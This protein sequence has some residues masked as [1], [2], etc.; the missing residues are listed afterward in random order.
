M[1]R[2]ESAADQPGHGVS[3]VVPVDP[4]ALLARVPESPWVALI[5]RIFR[6]IDRELR[7]LEQKA[8]SQLSELS[9]APAARANRLEAERLAL[10]GGV[11]Y[12]THRAR[13]LAL[14]KRKLLDFQEGEP[15]LTE[16]L[17]EAFARSLED[18][19]RESEHLR[20]AVQGLSKSINRLALDESRA[21]MR[22][23]SALGQ[24]PRRELVP[25]SE[26]RRRVAA[27]LRTINEELKDIAAAGRGGLEGRK[28]ELS[29]E[30]LRLI[31]HMDAW[32]QDTS[33]ELAR[34]EFH[35]GMEIMVANP[36]QTE[37]PES[38]LSQSLPSRPTVAQAGEPGG[39]ITVPEFVE[40]AGHG[41]AQTPRRQAPS[42]SHVG[43]PSE[44]SVEGAAA[45]LGESLAP[46]KG[47]TGTAGGSTRRPVKDTASLSPLPGEPRVRVSDE[48]AR[49]DM[50]REVPKLVPF[51]KLIFDKA[52]AKYPS[53]VV[54]GARAFLAECEA[55]WRA[56]LHQ[57]LAMDQPPYGEN[58]DIDQENAL[59][60]D[61]YNLLEEHLASA[62]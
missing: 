50:P 47:E 57:S 40:Q 18:C 11:A 1:T 14:T 49:P 51:N 7:W 2:K 53:L 52:A 16:A 17:Y 23:W 6:D 13:R 12:L 56:P 21:A 25:L 19:V 5:E 37:A 20:R 26:A 24:S 44:G 3:A 38:S 54:A 33:E 30:G 48:Q 35:H 31:A 42:Q 45:V 8:P 34:E 39:A 10:V 62:R 59:L 55:R 15:D 43:K 41:A 61:Y 27:R 4:E 46:T 32:E 60:D 9:S 29:A 22:A 28:A 36:L 58:D